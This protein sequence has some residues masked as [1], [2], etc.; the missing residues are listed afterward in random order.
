ML[1]DPDDRPVLAVLVAVDVWNALRQDMATGST[2]TREHHGIVGLP[3]YTDR[4]IPPG[5]VYKIYD[6]FFLTRLLGPS[7]IGYGLA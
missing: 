7:E 3:V 2:K 1:E 5:H 4:L 6:K